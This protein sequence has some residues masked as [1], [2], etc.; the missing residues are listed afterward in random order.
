MVASGHREGALDL[1]SIETLRWES[2][3]AYEESYSLQIVRRDAGGEPSAAP[4]EMTDG[5][6]LQPA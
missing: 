2:P 6:G 5:D 4:A 3:L 1:R